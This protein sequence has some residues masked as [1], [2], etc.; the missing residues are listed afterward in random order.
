[1]VSS[2]SAGWEGAV[3]DSDRCLHATP[4]PLGHRQNRAAVRR[5]MRLVSS[6]PVVIARLQA[7]GER[8]SLLHHHLALERLAEL[9]KTTYTI[10]HYAD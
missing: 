2:P 10:G 6:D 1:M 5:W 4:S 8:H 7:A 3:V 9:G